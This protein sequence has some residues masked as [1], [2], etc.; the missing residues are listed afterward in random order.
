MEVT[1]KKR[2]KLLAAVMSACMMAAAILPSFT[3]YA[4]DMNEYQ[5]QAEEQV[6]SEETE[7]VEDELEVASPSN[8]TPKEMVTDY[9]VAGPSDSEIWGTG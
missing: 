5:I 6:Q 2:K 8:A 7:F 1:M 3:A 4:E 9:T